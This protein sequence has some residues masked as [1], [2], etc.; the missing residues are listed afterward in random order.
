MTFFIKTFGCQMNVS[1][2][3]KIRHLLLQKGLDAADE[4]HADLIIVNGCAV[5]AKPQEKIFSYIGRVQ[6]GRDGRCGGRRK[7]IVAGCVAQTEKEGV[8]ARKGRVDFVVGTHQF[9]R[10]GEIVDEVLANAPP[11]VAAAFSRRWQ[12]LV[13]AAAA[14]DSAV[15]AF[16]SIM[17][18][19]DNFCSYCI[20]PF[21]RGR[22]KHR[23]LGAIVAEVESL[24]AQGFREIVLLGQNV[25]HWRDPA[26]GASF[27]Q[28]LRR[29]AAVPVRWVRFV[30][31]YPGYHDP[32][33]VAV[34]AGQRTIARHIH[35]PAQSGSTR[36][37]RRM[38]R[39]YTRSEYLRIVRSFRAAMPEMT[40]SSD[41]IVAFP[42]ESERDF[43]LTLQ[44]LEEVAYESIFSFIYSPRPRTKAAVLPMALP[45]A[46]AKA[47]LLVLQDLQER[48]QLTNNRRL[49]GET[50]EVLV[51]EPH[52]KRAGEMIG[53]SESYRVVNFA[54]RARP[55]EFARVRITA[56]GPHSLR[57]EEIA[58]PPA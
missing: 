58:P 46:E 21:T 7:I 9:Q 45:P 37:L 24:A 2:S 8:F 15:T 50:V 20:V 35:F 13:P 53:R 29:L 23:P 16:V 57:G 30:T 14:R 52:P 26:S 51:T 56:A 27:P 32:E 31:S 36:V 12:E 25:N 5:R 19:C 38:N 55:G 17:E 33:L 41:F 6:A 3:E 28:L 44:L 39:T 4:E 49:I 1:D 54:S 43:Q 11:R 22:E 40:F 34:M 18:G 42:G 48:I 47:R 10:I